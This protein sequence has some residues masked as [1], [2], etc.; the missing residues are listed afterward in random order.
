MDYEM[1]GWI[2]HNGLA[3]LGAIKVLLWCA[4]KWTDEITMD[5]IAD[6]K[7]IIRALKNGTGK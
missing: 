4:D 3:A 7:A 2:I 1:M 5:K 6:A